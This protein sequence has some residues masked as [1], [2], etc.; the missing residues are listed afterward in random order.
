MTVTPRILETD[1]LIVIH[2]F[3]YTSYAVQIHG[4]F[5]NN[6]M[7]I[8][9]HAHVVMTVAFAITQTRHC[10]TISTEECS[11]IIEFLSTG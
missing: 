9:V 6:Y 7:I 5:S 1:F 2:I 3:K 10:S 8:L 11:T 4:I